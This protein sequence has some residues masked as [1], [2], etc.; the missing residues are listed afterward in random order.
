MSEQLR[1]LVDTNILIPL[2][3]SGVVLKESLKNFVRF[4]GIGGH[5][6]LCHPASKVDLKR[7][8][9]VDRREALLSR[10]GQYEFLTDLPPCP[11]NTEQTSPNDSCDNEILYALSCHAAHILVTEDKGIHAKARIHGL[12]KNTFNIQTAEDFLRRLHGKQ[13]VELPNIQDVPLHN[14]SPELPTAFFDSLREDYQ[15][16]DNWFK[17]KAKEGRCAWIYR[18][19]SGVLGA[20]CIYT[21]QENEVINDAKDVLQGKALKLCTLKV[22]ESVRGRKIGELFLKASFK[23]ASENHCSNIFIHGNEEKQ[24]YLANLLED[25]GFFNKGTYGVDTVWVKEHP[26]EPPLSSLD[27]KDY[28]KY[29]FP[30]FRD[31][32]DISKYIVPIKPAYHDILFPDYESQIRT[33]MSLFR[34]DSHVG[35]AI[36]LAYLCSSQTKSIIPGDILLFYR[37]EDDQALTTL[38]IVDDFKV[39]Q[40]PSEIAALVK[41]RTVYTFDEIR[42]MSKKEVK[43]ILFRLVKHVPFP[44]ILTEL[45]KCGVL[46]GTPQSIVRLNEQKYRVV[47]NA[48]GI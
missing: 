34:S 32:E 30:H 40:D 8:S 33:Q 48:T 41:R 9:N 35:N 21:V 3:D 2:Q 18:D 27:P 45:E 23:Y 20:I 38:G 11:W 5:Q 1:F 29:Y 22:D 47:K 46:A 10:L 14:L 31:D 44:I 13:K 25:F 17:D 42:E 36:K 26:I 28:A 37:S 16:F 39:L 7:D 19:H 12:S 24:P 4:V 15:P 43:V 6:I